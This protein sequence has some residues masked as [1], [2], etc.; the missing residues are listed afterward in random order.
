V[1][2]NETTYTYTEPDIATLARV[3]LHTLEAAKCAGKMDPANLESVFSWVLLARWDRIMA[4][5]KDRREK[6]R[7][8]L[9]TEAVH[10]RGEH[11]DLDA[12]SM[13]VRPGGRTHE[14]EEIGRRSIAR[15]R[16]RTLL[17]LGVGTGLIGAL[18]ARKRHG[19]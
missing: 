5:T 17:I 9:R 14:G 11:M 12:R 7:N 8:R 18:Y 15:R 6:W 2:K 1:E 4:E 13:Y 3:P 10:D 19:V 16:F